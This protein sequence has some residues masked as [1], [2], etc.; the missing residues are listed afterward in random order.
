M[1]NLGYNIKNIKYQDI[2]TLLEAD[3][4]GGVPS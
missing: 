4:Y 1:T 3:I 2:L